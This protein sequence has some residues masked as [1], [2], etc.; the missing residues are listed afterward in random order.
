MNLQIEQRDKEGVANLD[1]KGTSVLGQEDT[2]P[3][4][5]VPSYDIL[6]FVQAQKQGRQSPPDPPALAE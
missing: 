3:E 5:A 1:L 6:E 4:R 2:L